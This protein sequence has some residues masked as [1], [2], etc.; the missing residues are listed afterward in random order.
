[1]VAYSALESEG[2]R[3]DFKESATIMG[4]ATRSLDV[5]E[6]CVDAAARAILRPN[7]RLSNDYHAAMM[8]FSSFAN[9]DGPISNQIS[10]EIIREGLAVVAPSDFRKSFGIAQDWARKAMDR[11]DRRFCESRLGW[12]KTHEP[13]KCDQCAGEHGPALEGQQPESPIVVAG[14]RAGRHEPDR[15]RADHPSHHCWRI[16]TCAGLCWDGRC[17]GWSKASALAS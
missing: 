6:F 4:G 17:S 5:A 8:A 7:R 11:L 12:T 10:R 2:F 16:S 15:R 3:P 13:F 9:S 14:G 1:M